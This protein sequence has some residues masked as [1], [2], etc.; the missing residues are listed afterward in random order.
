MRSLKLL[1]TG[2]GAPGIRGTLYA[3]RNNEAR[4]NIRIVGTD[5]SPD[6]VGRLWADSFYQ[7]TAPEYAGYADA[8]I[9]IAKK[10]GVDA[11]VP[12]TTREIAVFSRHRDHF[13]AAGIPV[14]VSSGPA[15][16]QA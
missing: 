12:Q 3:L 8:L 16:E 6:G 15:V 5:L 2:C 9:K 7:V 13:R 11:I 10:E 1:V 14:M 4:V